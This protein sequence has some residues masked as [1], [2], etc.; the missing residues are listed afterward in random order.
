MSRTEAID[1]KGR[2][3]P[4]QSRREEQSWKVGKQTAIVFS[5]WQ[6][7]ANFS[8]K[9]QDSQY[10]CADHFVSATHSSVCF[11]CLF[12]TLQKYKNHS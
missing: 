11:V 1:M 10:S 8:V 6:G 3:S 2:E 12:T 4:D 7:S 9:G 5:V